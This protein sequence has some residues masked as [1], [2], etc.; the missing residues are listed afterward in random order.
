MGGGY[1][2]FGEIRT[3]AVA[4]VKLYWLMETSL[5]CFIFVSSIVFI[6]VHW[7]EQSHL[8]TLDYDN[9]MRGLIAVHRFKMPTCWLRSFSDHIG[10]ILGLSMA[11]VWATDINKLV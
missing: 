7:C 1:I 2:N 3:S 6:V 10:L 11:F 5:S 8:S 4:T 9:A